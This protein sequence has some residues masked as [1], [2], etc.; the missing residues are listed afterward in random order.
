MNRYF[1]AIDLPEETK[2]S[3][4]SYFYPILTKY[5]YGS[6]TTEEKLHITLV[7][8]GNIEIKKEFVDFIKRL[9]ISY[10]II[11]KGVDAFPDLKNP[12]VLYAKV[13]N[14]LGPITKRISE[15]IG[16]RNKQ[17]F[18]PHITLCRIKK[19]KETEFNIPEKEFKFHADKI[20][21]FN[22]DFKNY[23]KLS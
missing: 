7:F 18:I 12:Q 8:L 19:I 3:I 21:I 17:E 16:I 14:D 10:D 4:Y 9:K 20:D 5:F 2:K 6:F 22:S 1:T 15:F 23:Y 11:I 13:N